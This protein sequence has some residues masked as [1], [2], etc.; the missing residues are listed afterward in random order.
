MET[1]TRQPGPK[2]AAEQPAVEQKTLSPEDERRK[3]RLEALLARVESKAPQKKEPEA[4]EPA[5]APDAAQAETQKEAE[6]DQE[7]IKQK[8]LARY[9]KM[10]DA[11]DPAQRP[12][13]LERLQAFLQMDNTDRPGAE[14]AAREFLAEKE[15]HDLTIAKDPE[16]AIKI[17]KKETEAKTET[18]PEK[19]TNLLFLV[20]SGLKRTPVGQLRD[21]KLRDRIEWFLEHSD[22]LDQVFDDHRDSTRISDAIKAVDTFLEESAQTWTRE[23]DRSAMTKEDEALIDKLE[24][25]GLIYENKPSKIGS[26]ETP[27]Q[28]TEATPEPIVA[29][30]QTP[31]PESTESTAETTE[32]SEAAHAIFSEQL[33]K[34]F[35]AAGTKRGQRDLKHNWRRYPKGHGIAKKIAEGTLSD[36]QQARV[37]AYA[38]L[39]D[40]VSTLEANTSPVEESTETPEPAAE[41]TQETPEPTAAERV[42]D[43]VSENS[44]EG[45]KQ[46]LLNRFQENPEGVNRVITTLEAVAERTDEQEK[47]LSAA[48]LAHEELT[49]PIKRESGEFAPIKDESVADTNPNIPAMTDEDAVRDTLQDMPAVNADT[50]PAKRVTLREMPAI[51]TSSGAKAAVRTTLR[52]MP[53]VEAP[54]EEAPDVSDTIPE[55]P[56]I[57][58][59]EAPPD[60]WWLADVERWRAADADGREAIVR[61]LEE[62]DA[63]EDVNKATFII[64]NLE[65]IEDGGIAKDQVM[66]TARGAELSEPPTASELEAQEFAQEAL[67]LE[68]ID[69][70]ADAS[71]TLVDMPA[72]EVSSP[73]ESEEFNADEVLPEN[74]RTGVEKVMERWEK[75][76]TEENKQMILENLNRL[77]AE[78]SKTDVRAQIAQVALERIKQAEAAMK[79]G[80][81]EDSEVTINQAEFNEQ[82]TNVLRAWLSEQDQEKRL[83]TVRNIIAATQHPTDR[84]L[85]AVAIAALKDIDNFIRT[86]PHAEGMYDEDLE[87]IDRANQPDPYEALD[88]FSPQE[89]PEEP[90]AESEPKKK[91]GFFRS[92]FGG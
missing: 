60:R 73:D 52:E 53:A 58:V 18:L 11:G 2:P 54:S 41:V 3:A 22:K 74:I 69:W 34:F 28:A 16:P 89:E 7:E 90:A 88:A 81:V 45:L 75:M 49:P 25:H 51:D 37:E 84:D 17:A 35:D 36:A 78:N 4:A 31:T 44:V 48:R 87:L 77:I 47:I 13:I 12:K 39:T 70:E 8:A 62:A 19:V 66:E 42:S 68:G 82:K 9:A 55:M 38:A 63:T 40:H 32:L 83:E 29:E 21:S 85:A 71:D 23:L 33:K 80:S 6:V 72:V 24:V 50:E 46:R 30:A 14:A 67:K 91:K 61:E 64:D 65:A 5:E 59:N 57:E 92:L 86:G 56:A 43:I 27:A 1:R 20:E 10:W 76:Q 79:I 15:G 26:P